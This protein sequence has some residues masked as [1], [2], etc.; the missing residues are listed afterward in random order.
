MANIQTH[1]ERGQR[2]QKMILGNKIDIEDR[3]VSQPAVVPNVGVVRVTG[4]I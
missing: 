3:A 2:I 1:A 4:G